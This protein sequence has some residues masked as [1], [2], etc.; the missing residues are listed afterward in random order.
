MDSDTRGRTPQNATI[1][2]GGLLSNGLIQGPYNGVNLGQAATNVPTLDFS[3][4][5]DV[6]STTSVTVSAMNQF[7]VGTGRVSLMVVGHVSRGGHGRLFSS[8]SPSLGLSGR[9]P[10]RRCLRGWM[11]RAG[12]VVAVEVSWT[13]C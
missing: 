12:L 1:S 13:E 5:G 11:V 7:Y 4:T 2:L 10:G 3:L 9:P 8:A 6:T